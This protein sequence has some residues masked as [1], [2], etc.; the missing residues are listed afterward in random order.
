MHDSV[1]GDLKPEVVILF[2]SGQDPVNQK[3]GGF[4]VVR[5]KSQLLD[6]VPSGSITSGPHEP[7]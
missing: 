2:F 3:I 5:F 6:G 7:N 1:S 4:K